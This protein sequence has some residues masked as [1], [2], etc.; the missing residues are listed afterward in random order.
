[1]CLLTF[2][3]YYRPDMDHLY[4]YLVFKELSDVIEGLS[5]K[6]ISLNIFTFVELSKRGDNLLSNIMRNSC[7]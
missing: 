6:S 5:E 3:N 7:T 2:I 1:M 4:T